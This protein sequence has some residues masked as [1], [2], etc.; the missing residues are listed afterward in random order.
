MIGGSNQIPKRNSEVVL[1]KLDVEH[2]RYSPRSGFLKEMRKQFVLHG[3]CAEFCRPCMKQI[4][5]QSFRVAQAY[6][7]PIIV[8]AL[9]RAQVLCEEVGI[10]WFY[11]LIS[12]AGNFRETDL[13]DLYYDFLV[14]ESLLREVLSPDVFSE[15]IYRLQNNTKVPIV[16]PYFAFHGYDE[17]S[18]RTTI[19][20]SLNWEE[21]PD[22][23]NL[24]DH[25][26][27]KVSLAS[28]F[29]YSKTY[30]VS[31]RRRELSFLVREGKLERND[32]LSIDERLL[33]MEE[34]REQLS[35][36][37]EYLELSEEEIRKSMS[38]KKN[39]H[40]DYAKDFS[41]VALLNPSFLDF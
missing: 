7:V 15:A 24:L 20:D 37:F 35:I 40:Y 29:L 17:S 13:H 41:K 12:N 5:S 6:N 25:T 30:G 23:K 8:K 39:S 10:Y 9:S 31:R 1:K 21:P 38:R 11:D 34:P 27:C 2:V 19:K 36:L 33:Q 32:A 22:S 4:M 26:D 18:I 3:G 14:Y 28:E 16:L